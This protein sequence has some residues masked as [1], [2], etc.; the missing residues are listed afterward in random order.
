MLA[1]HLAA[2]Q[3]ATGVDLP[4]VFPSCCA[5]ANMLRVGCESGRVSRL[6]RMQSENVA[7]QRLTISHG[8]DGFTFDCFRAS[9]Q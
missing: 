3:D 1:I 4:S 6:P 8:A 2:L 9:R 5:R 7:D